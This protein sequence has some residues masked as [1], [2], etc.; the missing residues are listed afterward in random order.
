M[1]TPVVTIFVVCVLVACL[2]L[3]FYNY[4]EHG[5]RPEDITISRHDAE[6][7]KKTKLSGD[8]QAA[9]QNYELA[10]EEYT[11]ALRVSSTDA[12]LYNDRGAAYYQLGL[13]NA[14]PPISEDEL[15]YGLEVDARLLEAAE[16]LALVEEKLKETNSGIITAVVNNEAA[17]KQIQSKML[18]LGH[19]V[20]VEEEA[21][22]D[23]T[24]F[25]LTIIVGKTRES[26]LN[27]QKDYL[28][29]IDIKYVKDKEGRKYSNYSVASRNL[30]TLYFRMGRKKE[31]M[32]QWRRALE[33][34]PTDDEL[35]ELIGSYE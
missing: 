2:A 29:A 32:I 26:F 28:K 15:D 16:S 6:K 35:R 21:E 7:L 34:E 25:W 17:S 9:L 20:H 24:E 14:N 33:L 4:R 3:A 12:F 13:E 11:K 22:D 30:G 8:E 10:I 23:D 1:K 31:A 19:F 18:S 5:A 27:A